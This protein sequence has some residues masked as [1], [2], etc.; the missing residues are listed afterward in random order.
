MKIRGSITVF[1]SIILA[2]LIAFAGIVVDLSRYRV[3]EK[4]A[5][6]AV[7]LSIQSAL[8][9]YFAP[10]K[11]H[12]GIFGTGQTTEELEVL[13]YD[14]I[15][16]NL[17]VENK[18]MPGIVDLFGF[19]VDN[20]SVHPMLNLADEHV[21][22]QQITQFM[23][24]RAPVITI[25][26]FL[27]KLKALN[28]FMAQSGLLNKKMDLE[29]KL[30]KVREEQVYLSLLLDERISLYSVNKKPMDKL[31]DYLTSM[32]VLY[33]DIISLERPKEELDVAYL[34][35]PPL[36]DRIS[37][38]RIKINSIEKEILNLEHELLPLISE[39]NN[40][41][42][43]IDSNKDDIKDIEKEIKKLEDRISK[44][45]EKN[46]A[47][48]SLISSYKEQIDDLERTI[49]N[50]ENRISSLKKD[51]ERVDEDINEV[52]KKISI[53]NT[54]IKS[55]EK[56]IEKEEKQLKSEINT[57][58]NILEEI[59]HKAESIEQKLIEINNIIMNYLDYHK[60]SIKLISNI[61]KRSEEISRLSKDIDSEIEKQSENS[62][63]SFLVRIR[64]DIKK[65]VLNTSPD[66]LNIIKLDLETNIA[67]LNETNDIVGVSNKQISEL[68]GN[69]EIFIDKTKEIY[70]SL[71]YFEREVFN[72]KMHQPIK[73]VSEQ[74][75][76]SASV[77]K[78]SSYEIEPAINK[79]EKNE[80]NRWCNK[81]FDEAN[82]TE[83]RDKGYEKKLRNNIKKADDKGK[84]ERQKSFKGK[85]QHLSDKELEQLFSKLP[86]KKNDE[87]DSLLYSMEETNTEPED[88]YK[89]FL[90]KNGSIAAEIGNTLS[91]AGEDLLKTLYI[92]EYI[93]GTLNNANIENVPT[94]RI[95][96][97]G[98]PQKRFFEKSEV[99]YILF[100]ANKENVNASLTQMALFGIRMG[101]NLIHVYTNTDKTAAA[102][103]AAISISGW[104]GFGVP[105]IK[106]LIL[107]GWAAGES[108]LDVKDINKG[109]DVPVYKTKNTWRLNLKSIFT[110]IAG[111]FLD[112]SSQWLKQ[113]KDEWIDK[114]DDALQTM[115]RDIVSS[116]VH[117]AFLPLE[118]AITEFGYETDT[119]YD[120]EMVSLETLNDINDIN[121]LE[122]WVREACQKQY[123][124]V[125]GRVSNWTK[126]KLE[127]YKKQI[128]N[129]IVDFLF[130]SPG[131]K[132]FVSQLKKGID[133]I[134]DK[135]VTQLS[136]S[137]KEIGNKVEDQGVQS[138]LVGTVVS[139]DYT[140][141]LRLLLFAV[142]QKTKL[143]RA[144][145]LMQL[146]MRETLDNPDFL[147]SEYNAFLIVE[148]DISMKFMFIPSFLNK[149]EIG[150]FK[151][152]WGYGY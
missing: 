89:Q 94:H 82:E 70:S 62:D 123:L 27:E 100:G 29:N 13:V 141:Y 147:M 20:V 114:G 131:Y 45:E 61:L 41:E 23:K 81:V 2:V 93:I 58:I 121:Q 101:L 99:E 143:L 17:S 130:N 148:A 3:A 55:I 47:D 18:F 140:D 145:D 11:E 139:F 54:E 117:E 21:L 9:Q 95:S 150:K 72:A 8:T 37:E 25:G 142:P 127:D 42:D 118:Q 71:N 12:Y 16:K 32:S 19:S 132:K 80:F 15:E 44:E 36:I 84:E 103:T 110:G 91:R 57:C 125:K 134:I 78:I 76:L 4:H 102:M 129:K 128:T 67:S 151:I 113:T 73:D 1:I 39:F 30:Q 56:S 46:N 77:Y 97:Y 109:E 106:N 40:I 49:S 136:D 52:K 108:F 133:N 50:K 138:Q 33:K 6:A 124:S 149:Y 14:L 75:Y 87:N 105:I 7:Q 119:A 60:E 26:N 83:N 111:E 74:I 24:Y 90:N 96:L 144:A 112:E 116:A 38:A 69:I 63:N 137:L 85:D 28:T 68:I 135:G 120:I 48:A 64:A 51:L 88:Y 104:T 146:N 10:L 5:R 115:V 79:K 126:V 152:R 92:N 22:E 53:K 43:R 122:I 31:K 59:K 86:S 107:V 34:A 98:I 35:M 65:L 66:I